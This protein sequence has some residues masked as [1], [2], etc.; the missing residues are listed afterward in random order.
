[1]NDVIHV[2]Y[3]LR[4]ISAGITACWSLIPPL[5]A[6]RLTGGGRRK[7]PASAARRPY[8]NRPAAGPWSWARGGGR[9]PSRGAAQAAPG[10]VGRGSLPSLP[11]LPRAATRGRRH[12][13]ETHRGSAVHRRDPGVIRVRT[14]QTTRF[15]LCQHDTV[16]ATSMPSMPSMPTLG[17]VGWVGRVARGPL[18]ETLYPLRSWGGASCRMHEGRC[19]LPAPVSAHRERG[20]GEGFARW[21]QLFRHTSAPFSAPPELITR[22]PYDWGSLDC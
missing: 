17:G 15:L 16:A 20:W 2:S 3:G 14:R 11:T 8:P 18:P 10:R 22:I 4:L 1:L 13:G 7:Q 6:R 5:P 19:C 9:A 12:H 21:V